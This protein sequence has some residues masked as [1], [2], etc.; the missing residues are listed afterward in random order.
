MP[1]RYTRA[2]LKRYYRS[3]VQDTVILCIDVNVPVPLETLINCFHMVP[4][5]L[6]NK[7]DAGV[8]YLLGPDALVAQSQLSV[9]PMGG[10]LFYHSKTPFTSLEKKPCYQPL[11]DSLLNLNEQ[12]ALNL[13]VIRIDL[14][15]SS[16]GRE[17]PLRSEPLLL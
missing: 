6:I 2:G 5:C 16:R 14:D 17:T 15:L 1:F 4:C 3:R 9:I 8:K 10:F 13:G 7:L 12:P 11:P